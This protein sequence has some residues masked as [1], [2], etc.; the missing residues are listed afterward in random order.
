MILI[1]KNILNFEKMKNLIKVNEQ[2]P[3]IQLGANVLFLIIG[4]FFI[5]KVLFITFIITNIL[6]NGT[7]IIIKKYSF[8]FKALT[9]KNNFA[10][11]LNN[12][13]EELA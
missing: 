5:N 6:L 3:K 8:L 7:S 12:K 9:L 10:K 1:I 13:L 11:S 4:V 2:V